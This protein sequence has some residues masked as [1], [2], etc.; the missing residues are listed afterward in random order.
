M[1][2]S[3]TTAFI[4]QFETEVHMAFQR[5]GS[6]LMGFTRAKQVN[7]EKTTFFKAGKGTAGTKTRHGLVPTM[8]L[9]HSKVECPVADYYAADY[10]DEL[11]EL[12]F[13]IDERAIV[14]KSGASALGRKADDLIVTAL[15]A[16]TGNALI[17]A[18]GTGLVQSKIN[19]T[20]E[21]LGNQDVPD[22]GNRMWAIGPE[23]WTD[24]LGIS[25]FSDADFVG[26]DDLPYKGGMVARRWMGFLFFPFTGLANGAG[27]ATET[28]SLVWHKICSGLGI[29]KQVTT[30]VDW[31]PERAAHLV[32]S[33]MSLGSVNIDETGIQTVDYVK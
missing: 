24:L 3:V 16:A 4:T 5:E 14:A 28:R 27:G 6:K 10:V 13:N 7:G 1:S 31:I 29:G 20:F 12:K 30:K 21:R 8:S 33:N 2:A 23:G 26:A 25:A 15:S 17:A 22:D 19:T 32:S 11:D 9:D 18:G